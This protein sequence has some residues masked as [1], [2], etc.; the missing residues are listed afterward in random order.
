MLWNPTSVSSNKKTHITVVLY[1]K[2]NSSWGKY[3]ELAQ[4]L[5][6]NIHG[7]VSDQFQAQIFP[8]EE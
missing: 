6:R 3:E 2:I 4:Y 7:K 8:Q 5:T 1:V